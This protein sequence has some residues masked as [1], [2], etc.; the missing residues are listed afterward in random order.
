MKTALIKLVLKWLG[1]IT[2]E[3]WNLAVSVVTSIVRDKIQGDARL[4]TFALRMQNLL[5]SQGFIANLLREAA[6]A[7]VRKHS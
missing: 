3:Q 1:G 6:V 4:T 2:S 7:F 5:P